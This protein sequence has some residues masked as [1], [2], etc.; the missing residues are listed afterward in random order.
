MS[1]PSPHPA[2]HTRE[3]WRPGAH[4]P[5]VMFD[6]DGTLVDLASGDD[7]LIEARSGRPRPDAVAEAARTLARLQTAIR[8]LPGARQL[9]RR[10]GDA[11]G[12]VVLVTAGGSDLDQLLGPLGSTGSIR[13]VV[14]AS[15]AGRGEPA[16]DL[17]LAALERCGVGSDEAIVVGDAVWDVEA[18]AAASVPCVGVRSGGID[19]CSLHDAG[20]LAVFDDCRD[21]VASFDMNP[22]GELLSRVAGLREAGR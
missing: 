21:I 2:D 18:A 20:A 22:V 5:A 12:Q 1:T 14:D 17:Y 15:E 4:T 9:W 16:P 19:A 3:P 8:E 6:F 11:G 13:V 10:I 7:E